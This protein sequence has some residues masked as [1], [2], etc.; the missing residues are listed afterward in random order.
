MSERNEVKAAINAISLVLS[1]NM[2]AFILANMEAFASH[3]N[4]R[5][6]RLIF[7][8]FLRI[9]LSQLIYVLP[10]S[11]WAQSQQNWGFLKGTI[12]AAIFT[13]LINGSCGF[14]SFK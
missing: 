2:I 13:I 3:S 7:E 6:M 14:L 1:L 11:F 5:P 10:L 12:V 9:G 8:V 4:N